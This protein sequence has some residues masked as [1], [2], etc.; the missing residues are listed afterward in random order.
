MVTIAREDLR[1]TLMVFGELFVNGTLLK[2]MDMWHAD[3]WDL[4]E[5]SMSLMLQMHGLYLYIDVH[6]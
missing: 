3:N 1:L 4:K 2:L 6:M 5:S